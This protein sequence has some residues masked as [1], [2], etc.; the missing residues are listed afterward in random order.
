MKKLKFFT[1]ISVFFG[2]GLIFFA[3]CKKDKTPP[4][5]TFDFAIDA[6][7]Y[8]VTFTNTSTD[9]DTYLWDFGDGSTSTL[10]SPSHTYA[11]FG[12]YTVKLTA[13]GAGGTNQNTQSVEL[14]VVEPITIDGK[15]DDW[16]NIP[17]LY[18]FSDGEGRTLTEARVTDSKDYLYFYIKGTSSIGEVI[19]VYIDADNNG[20]TGWGYW[21]FYDTPGIE[22]L[23][24]A[25]IVQF[26]DGT[27][28][29]SVLKTAT[30]SDSNWP[31]EDFITSNAM[32]QS[33]G[34]VTSGSDKVIEFSLLK[35][36][37]S[38]PALGKSIRIVYGNS[39][40]TWTNVGTLPQNYATPLTVPATYTMLK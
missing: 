18:K 6:T 36:M 38:H 3:G 8:I 37:F 20:T 19:Q 32:T 9:A 14:D 17:S 29:S 28:P 26:P 31:W 30:G 39:D 7:G 40:N 11:D 4:V 33:S 2:I 34:Y 5:A 16:N 22:Y 35:D 1:L 10:E 15:F 13:T 21:N 23:M 27:K 24:E 12:T 25:V